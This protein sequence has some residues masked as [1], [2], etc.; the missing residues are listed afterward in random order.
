M[1]SLIVVHWRIS[2]AFSSTT[3]G[4]SLRTS[5]CFSE[6]AYACEAMVSDRMGKVQLLGLLAKSCGGSG[7]VEGKGFNFF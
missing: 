2:V 4:Y 7:R 3:T 5:L 1:T 6:R